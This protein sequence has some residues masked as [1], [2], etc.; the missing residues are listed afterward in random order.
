MWFNS[1][2]REEPYQVL[3]YRDYHSE[4]YVI[5]RKGVTG[6]GA[7]WLSSARAVRCQVKSFNERNPYCQLPSGHAGD[8]GETAA[9]AGGRWGRRQVI[10]ALIT[11]ATHVLQWVVQRVAR[12]QRRANP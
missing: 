4:S 2:Q 6:T 11:W 9:K 10:M 7:A 3:T 1:K 12:R 8:S 5:A